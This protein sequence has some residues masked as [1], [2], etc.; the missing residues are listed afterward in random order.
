MKKS[1]NKMEKKVK[2]ASTPS[3]TPS[4]T[5]TDAQVVQQAQQ[6]L[7]LRRGTRK[8]SS[9]DYGQPPSSST[10][11]HAQVDQ[12]RKGK[13]LKIS[14]RKSSSGSFLLKISHR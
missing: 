3:V 10:P 4:S 6:E 12:S 11:T 8:R 9:V 2:K 7:S 14:S 13:K 1:F 5:P